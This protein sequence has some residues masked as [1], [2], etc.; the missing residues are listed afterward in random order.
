MQPQ[1]E[2][3]IIQTPAEAPSS[4]NCQGTGVLE[5]RLTFIKGWFRLETIVFQ[6]ERGGPKNSRTLGLEA[7]EGLV[8]DSSR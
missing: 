3:E 1:G 8:T 7:A 6:S 2:T 5:L 4:Q